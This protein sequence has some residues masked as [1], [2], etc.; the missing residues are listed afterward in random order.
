MTIQV[1]T[2]DGPQ[3]TAY[4][5]FQRPKGGEHPRCW[6]IFPPRIRTCQETRPFF[7][8]R[9]SCAGYFVS[10]TSYIVFHA[11]RQELVASNFLATIPTCLKSGSLTSGTMFTRMMLHETTIGNSHNH[12]HIYWDKEPCREVM[13][14]A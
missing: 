6:P 12:N 2:G 1:S 9:S 11:T 7:H 5:S 4:V 8:V 14:E 10:H 3:K 13:S